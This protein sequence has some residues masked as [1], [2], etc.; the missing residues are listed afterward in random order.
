[1]PKG[2]DEQVKVCAECGW[3]IYGTYYTFKKLDPPDKGEEIY[4]HKRCAEDN[5]EKI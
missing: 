1:M 5:Y 2:I 4:L 3:G